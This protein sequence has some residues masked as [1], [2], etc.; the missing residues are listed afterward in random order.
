[1]LPAVTWTIYIVIANLGYFP[2]LRGHEALGSKATPFFLH[3]GLVT[4]LIGIL[5]FVWRLHF[6]RTLYR[7]GVQVAGCITSVSFHRDRGRIEY[8]YLCEGRTY[9]SCA[10][11][12]KTARTRG[13]APETAVTL[14]IDQSNPQRSLIFDLYV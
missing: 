7:H 13:L 4:T 6:F 8:I 5:L 14:L 1:M 11:V 12:M 3:A 9:S 10:A 2:A